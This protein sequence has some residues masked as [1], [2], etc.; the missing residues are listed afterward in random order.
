[1]SRLALLTLGLLC[2]ALPLLASQPAEAQAL[3]GNLTVSGPGNIVWNGGPSPQITL[4]IENL[5]G[6]AEDVVG[7]QLDL[8]LVP[9]IGQSAGVLR[10]SSISVAS[11]NYIF[12]GN[13]LMYPD[14][15][16]QPVLSSSIEDFFDFPLV[17]LQTVAPGSP[18]GLVT[19]DFDDTDPSP[20]SGYFQIVLSAFGPLESWYFPDGA[21]ETPFANTLDGAQSAV[22]GVIG[23]NVEAEPAAVPESSALQLAG[24]AVAILLAG[25]AR[26]RVR[27]TRQ[28]ADGAR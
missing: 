21:S 15:L 11:S 6:P 27:R 16:P 10:F 19:I 17:G 12:D 8:S 18:F 28:D 2:G 23:I 14:Q 7:F 20:P 9:V 25:A 13:S 22:L 1:M 24:A 5:P 4:M 26:H 3:P